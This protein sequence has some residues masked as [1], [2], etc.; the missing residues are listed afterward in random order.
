M[1]IPAIGAQLYIFRN[2]FDLE[3]KAELETVLRSLASA[4][5]ETIEGF[6]GKAA[7]YRDLLEKYNLRY[8]GAHCVLPELDDAERAADYVARMQGADICSSGLI[9]WNERTAADY[10]AAIERLNEKGRYFRSRGIFL[11]YHNHDF[12][13][14]K[15]NGET[16]GMDLLLAGLDFS[17]VSLCFD[18]GWAWRAGLDPADF[19]KKHREK[20]GVVHL[21]DFRGTESVEL[22]AGDISLDAMLAVLPDLPNLRQ[23]IVEQDPTAAEPAQRMKTSRD[24]LRNRFGI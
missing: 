16:T 12:E 14:E 4:G 13:F 6:L 10:H 5:Y 17:S 15:V 9:R 7:D 21:R 23:V 22:G 2:T 11:H 19:L 3:S 24:Y 18:T 8:A 1:P 20:I